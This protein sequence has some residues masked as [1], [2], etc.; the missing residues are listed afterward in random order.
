MNQATPFVISPFANPSGKVVFRVSG[1]LDGKYIR[2]NLRTR[3]EAEAERQVLEVR[4]L[5]GETATRTAVTRLADDQL[6]EAE[7]VFHRLEGKARS[8]S[9]YVEYALAN[10]REPVTQKLLTE[11][12]TD[13]VATKQHEHEQDLLSEPH[14]TRMKRDLKRLEKHFPSAT[15]AELTGARLIG[16]F[17]ARGAGLKTYNNRRGIVSTFLKFALQRDWIADNPLAKIPPR[18]IRRRGGCATTFAA[19]QAA[20]LMAHVEEHYPSAVPFFALCLFAGIRPCLRTG[21]ILRLQPGSV[22]L[23][24]NLIR[25]DGEVS[26]IREPR[27]VTIQ[28]N[29]AAWLR[30]YP[31]KQHPIIPANL[32]HIR[33]KVAKSFPLS[34]DVMRHTFISMFVAKFRSIGEASIQAGN[35]ESIIRKHYLDLKSPAEA[36]AFFGILPKKVEETAPDPAAFP[37]PDAALGIA[38]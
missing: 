2:K 14:L 8:L 23:D 9:F 5:Q 30:A 12:V 22:K 33:E 37:E 32:Q 27:N 10:F 34:H 16:Y 21:E 24:S 31:L 17:E 7:A 6:H 26:K 3:P 15:V 29:L 4:S 11:A 1:W 38:V 13:Y 28:P 20:G 36:A 18:R 25:I 19:S 35:S